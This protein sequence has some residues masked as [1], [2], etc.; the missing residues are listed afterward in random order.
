MMGEALELNVWCSLEG[1]KVGM[2]TSLITRC[3]YCGVK[4]APNQ[5]SNQSSNQSGL[6][7]ALSLA[8]GLGTAIDHQKMLIG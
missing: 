8:S 5:S 1:I 4:K 6:F 3:N 2:G 7:F